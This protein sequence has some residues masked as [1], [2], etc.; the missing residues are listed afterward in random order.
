MA[1]SSGGS[2][3]QA[4][5]TSKEE[6]GFVVALLSSNK[7]NDNFFICAGKPFVITRV[8]LHNILPHSGCASRPTLYSIDLH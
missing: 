1:G 5:A 6:A 7:R 4:A 8:P 2:A 3:A